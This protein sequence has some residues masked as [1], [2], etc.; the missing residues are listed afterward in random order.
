[1]S[2]NNGRAALEV[3]RQEYGQAIDEIKKHMDTIDSPSPH[4]AQSVARVVIALQSTV[5]R[6]ILSAMIASPDARG[7][8]PIIVT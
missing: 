4:F 1:M 5:R 2:N 6:E 3:Q 8:A 7:Q